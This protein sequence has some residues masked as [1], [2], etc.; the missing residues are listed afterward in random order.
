M[1]TQHSQKEKLKI[2]I[3]K[4][5]KIVFYLSL[6]IP[7]FVKTH[8][9]QKAET[10]DSLLGRML[11]RKFPFLHFLS[12]SFLA[13]SPVL[14]LISITIYVCNELSNYKALSNLI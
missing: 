14:S 1:K 12:V 9:Y 10:A 2:K 13:L 11:C 6:H 5:D 3:N 4:I 7:S 8:R